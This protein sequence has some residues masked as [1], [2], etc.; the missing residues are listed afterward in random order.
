MSQ[1]SCSQK[2]LVCVLPREALV[3]APAG[4]LSQS[5]VANRSFCK[6]V[7]IAMPAEGKLRVRPPGATRPWRRASASPRAIAPDD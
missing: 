2:A 5:M 4:P 6:F 3:N 7:A 1:A